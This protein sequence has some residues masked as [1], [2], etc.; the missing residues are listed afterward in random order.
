MAVR[1]S[2]SQTWLMAKWRE[3]KRP[4][5]VLLPQRMWSSTRAWARWL[6]DLQVLQ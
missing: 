2:S 6:S 4:K 5:P 1:D 3:G